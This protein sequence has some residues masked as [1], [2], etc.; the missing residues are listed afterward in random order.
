MTLQ[1]AARIAVELI[2]ESGSSEAHNEAASILDRLARGFA[3]VV[4]MGNAF[5]GLTLFGPFKDSTQAQ[6]WNT[7]AGGGGTIASV[8]HIPGNLDSEPNERFNG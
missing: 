1:Q 8:H 7:K 2:Q 3:N 5:T 6:E 4:A